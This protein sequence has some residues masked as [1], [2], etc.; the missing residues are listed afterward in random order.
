MA[1]SRQPTS[2]RITDSGRAPAAKLAPTMIEN[3]TAAAGAMWVIDWNRTSLRPIA[4]RARPGD[5]LLRATARLLLRQ[6][7]SRQHCERWTGGGWEIK[8]GG[9]AAAILLGPFPRW[10]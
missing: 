5:E 1:T 10:R 3:A 4:S 2:A 8:R 6:T 9:P 7:S